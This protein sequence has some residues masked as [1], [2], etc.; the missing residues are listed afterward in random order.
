MSMA[1]NKLQ[2]LNYFQL[3]EKL[4]ANLIILK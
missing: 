2:H 3:F 4:K 1:N